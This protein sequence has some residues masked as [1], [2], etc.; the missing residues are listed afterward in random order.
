MIV[1]YQQLCL[2]LLVFISSCLIEFGKGTTEYT[3]EKDFLD[4]LLSPALVTRSD[5]SDFSLRGSQLPS[6]RSQA[7]GA[8]WFSATSFSQNSC[9]NGD[10]IQSS[11]LATGQCLYSPSVDTSFLIS[12]NGGLAFL[13]QYNGAGG[14]SGSPSKL[15]QIALDRCFTTSLADSK[16]KTVL[17]NT[18]Q[19][20]S[21]GLS[22]P[23]GNTFVLYM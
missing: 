5:E 3:T 20:S 6:I 21:S 23:L 2:F 17:S 11:G 16:N 8:G 9:G 10:V 19:C 18:F 4:L 15:S 22:L 13:N 1:S 12:C 14:C 7:A